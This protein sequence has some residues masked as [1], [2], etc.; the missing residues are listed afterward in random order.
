MHA[1]AE[2]LGF[3]EFS[4]N[5]LNFLWMSKFFLDYLNFLWIKRISLDVW[6]EFLWKV[7]RNSLDRIFSGSNFLWIDVEG[8]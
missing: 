6:R 1:D 3:C 7:Q 5:Y 4:L 2:F 8:P